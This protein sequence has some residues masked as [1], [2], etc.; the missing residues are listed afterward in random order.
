MH[1]FKDHVDEASGLKFI[2]LLPPKV[3]HAIKRYA[4]QDKYKG[5]LAMYRELKK[6]KDIKS[7]K[8]SNNKIKSIAADYF[9][10]DHKE[11]DKI[12]NR[13]T[14]YEE[15]PP[16]MSNTVKKF[17]ADGMDP[18][19][20]FALAWSIYNQK[21]NEA[22]EYITEVNNLSRSVLARNPVRLDAFIKKVKKGDG[23]KLIN[24]DDTVVLH[25]DMI[26]GI[27]VNSNPTTDMPNKPKD[28]DGNILTW[29]SLEKTAEFGGQ[30][31][32]KEPTGAEW[33]ALISVGVNRAVLGNSWKLGSDEWNNIEKFWDDY[34][35]FAMKL[36]EEFKTRY[37]LKGL[38]QLGA[39][40]A[41]TS[42]EWKKTGANDRTPKTDM[43]NDKVHI[44]LKKSGGSQL[45]S[46]QAAET[47]STFNAAMATYSGKNPRGLIKLMSKIETDMGKMTSK[48]SITALKKMRDSGK[49]LSQ[50]DED[51]LTEFKG[52]DKI[53]K[54]LTAQM[55]KIFTSDDFKSHFC[56]EAATGE[57]KF[58]IGAD[59][60]ATHVVTFHPKGYIE[61]DLILDSIQGAGM[62]LAKKNSFYVAFKGG[63]RPALVTRAKNESFADIVKSECAEFLTEEMEQ[64]DEFALFDRL[65]KQ[66][67][68]VSNAIKNQAGK[69]IDRIM[70]RVSQAFNAMKK[71]GEKMMAGLLEFFN[72][73]VDKIKVSGGGDFPLV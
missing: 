49:K 18:D 1:S 59:A 71:M 42:A 45:M 50:A 35:P 65:K 68:N 2:S 72:F 25:K 31:A 33:E 16:G 6:N 47:L 56:W 60:T 26:A 3:R 69:I 66:A 70:I 9:N 15:A 39:S 20:A 12:L 58:G 23:F 64:L 7:R 51:K 53:A 61:A 28:V 24:T 27:T 62:T 52:L 36:G 4:H 73:E 46:G 43:I 34:G 5:A 19:K 17:K 37:K 63:G 21:K 57:T 48:T 32:S 44:S 13:K 29:A 30:G 67:R 14:R 55:N 22:V 11:F 54:D 41:P 10:L 8:L 38:K 40:T